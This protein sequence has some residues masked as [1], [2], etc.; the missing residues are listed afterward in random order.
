MTSIHQLRRQKSS[1]QFARKLL[2]AAV[3]FQLPF[4]IEIVLRQTD[5]F[6]HMSI[7]GSRQ[8]PG[9][10]TSLLWFATSL[11]AIIGFTLVCRQL[12]LWEG[13][14]ENTEF[15]QHTR[16]LGSRKIAASIQLVFYLVFLMPV[17]NLIPVIWARF[18]A[19]AAIRDL[20]ALMPVP[21]KQQKSA[22]RNTA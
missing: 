2:T 15:A 4:L 1:L 5:L 14:L 7:L 16:L 21:R 10:V 6:F 22:A 3:L 19:S 17:F 8:M 11:L 20:D 13:D 18:Q 12:S 9:K